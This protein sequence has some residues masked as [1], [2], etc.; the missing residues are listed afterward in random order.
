M[1]RDPKKNDR[2]NERNESPLAIREYPK[3][4]HTRESSFADEVRISL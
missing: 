1:G 4:V 3:V 2:M